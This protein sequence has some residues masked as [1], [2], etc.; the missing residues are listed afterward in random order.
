MNLPQGQLLR[1]RVLNS[2]GTVLE[3]AL[4]RELTGYARLEPQD[5]LLLDSERSGVLTFE[6]GVPCA[7]YHPSTD[8]GGSN[9]LT[10]IAS[11]GPYRLELYE[12]DSNVLDSV[13][14]SDS[15]VVPP[16]LPAQILTGNEQL[17]ERT[18]ER[19]PGSQRE[20]ATTEQSGLGAVESF[21]DDE[22]RIKTIRDQ[23]RTEAHSRARDWNLPVDQD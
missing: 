18:R 9:A 17:A 11:S 10:K 16:G 14:E 20:T 7:V 15:L 21:L 5:A 8:T 3:G 2:L 1:R 6:N 13:H 19:A 22:N 23:A 4:E 12:L